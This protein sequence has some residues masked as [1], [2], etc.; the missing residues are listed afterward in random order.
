MRRD[1]VKLLSQAGLDA[2]AVENPCLPGTPD[3]EC[4]PGWIE[5]KI[6]NG[7]PV[8]S[9]TIVRLPKFRPGQR[10]WLRQRAA[11]G[12]RCWL[13]L[14]VRSDWL[15]FDGA[16]ASRMVGLV[17]RDELFAKAKAA[18]STKQQM[19]EELPGCLSRLPN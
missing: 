19:K 12:G 1:V 5:L 14:R 2:M 7:W 13:L 9:T 4:I 16:Y 6:L 17:V 10:L 18:W 11:A 8:R 3:V 15:L